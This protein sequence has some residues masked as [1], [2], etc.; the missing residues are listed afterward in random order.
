M[1]CPHCRSCVQLFGH[2]CVTNSTFLSC[3]LTFV[4]YSTCYLVELFISQFS[5][6]LW[7]T[8]YPSSIYYHIIPSLD[9]EYFEIMT[10][11]IGTGCGCEIIGLHEE[12]VKLLIIQQTLLRNSA[13]GNEIHNINVG[14]LHKA[15]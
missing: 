6:W 4:A 13:P 11:H 10:T 9:C 14:C 8:L 12:K 1:R 5:V 15:D 3:G 7:R 2:S